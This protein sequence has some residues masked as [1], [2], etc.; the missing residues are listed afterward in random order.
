ME[1]DEDGEIDEELQGLV[2]LY[3]ET[4]PKPIEYTT[5]DTI[6]YNPHPIVEI[7]I[8]DDVRLSDLVGREFS[9]EA[10]ESE[11]EQ[12]LISRFYYFEH[13]PLD[14]NRISIVS[15]TDSKTYTIKWTGS[16]TDPNHYDGSKDDAIIEIEAAF[17]QWSEATL[18]LD[19]EKY[20]SSRILM[21]TRFSVAL[22][23]RVGC[24]SRRDLDTFC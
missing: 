19:R 3:A 14:N 13:E 1:P 11:D 7:Y 21:A 12:D 15:M 20:G 2:H 18:R 9:V 4:D 23:T 17:T 22:Q 16:C 5:D 6:A 24:V 10:G 8:L